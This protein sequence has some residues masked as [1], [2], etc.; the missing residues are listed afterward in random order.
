MTINEASIRQLVSRRESPTLDFKET[1][2]DNSPDGSAELAKDLMAMANSLHAGEYG[3]LLFGV[4]EDQMEH[5]G[6]I[7]GFEPQ[8]WIT[9]SNLQQKVKLLLNR[10][11][12]F[13]WSQTNVDGC[14]IGVIEV[15]SG[16][17]PFFPLRDG[18]K[19][20]RFVAL[21]RI[22]SSTDA[23]SPDEIVGWSRRDDNQ[24]ANDL[25]LEH[26]AQEVLV[27]PRLSSGTWTLNIGRRRQDIHVMNDGKA[28]F[29]ISAA[30]CVWRLN[31]QAW[32]QWLQ[33]VSARYLAEIPP[34]VQRLR[35]SAGSIRAGEHST[36]SFATELGD[37][38]KH[39]RQYLA[40]SVDGALD[41][42][43]PLA[44]LLVGKVEVE[45]QGLRGC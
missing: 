15:R 33:S 39:V 11:P 1:F 2:Y 44:E 16:G 21:H 27:K 28:L 45:C 10:V 7:K 18:K 34:Y 32:R 17:R 14:I 19:L 3:Y 26:L 4:A 24:R 41:M 37:V 12:A 43:L 25:Q 23:A 42:A 5:L 13:S 6:V 22:G 31:E 20:H 9:D 30:R 38:H 36:I 40:S 35:V 8:E 29:S